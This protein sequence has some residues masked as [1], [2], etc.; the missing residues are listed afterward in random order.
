[1][2][3]S[4]SQLPP[5]SSKKASTKKKKRLVESQ[6]SKEKSEVKSEDTVSKSV[7]EMTGMSIMKEDL[8]VS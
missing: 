4:A 6:M 3:E 5:R 1:M 2:S 7:G 8:Q